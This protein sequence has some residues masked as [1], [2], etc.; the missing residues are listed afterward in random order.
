[1]MKKKKLKQHVADLESKLRMARLN[2]EIW[3]DMFYRLMADL[4][5]YC[6]ETQIIPTEPPTIEVSQTEDDVAKYTHGIT[7]TPPTLLFDFS[8]HDAKIR[9]EMAIEIFGGKN[10]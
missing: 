7:T 2:E 3:K 1:M 10:V 8:E 4:K 6:V 9:S 5:G